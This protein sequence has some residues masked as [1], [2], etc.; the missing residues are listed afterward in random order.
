MQR[1]FV[2]T[3]DFITPLVDELVSEEETPYFPL[4]DTA[5]ESAL[6]AVSLGDEQPNTLFDDRRLAR[7]TTPADYT[8]SASC[9][10]V[11][12]GCPGADVEAQA[13]A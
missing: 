5:I 1:A 13:A 9:L 11:V 4:V 10:G 2:A 8:P 6:A 3:F 12:P 7:D